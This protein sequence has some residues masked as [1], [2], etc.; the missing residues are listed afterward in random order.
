MTVVQTSEPRWTTPIPT[1]E[2]PLRRML[3][4]W[5]GLRMYSFWMRVTVPAMPTFSPQ[6]VGWKGRTSW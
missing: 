1:R 5:A 4:R 2:N 6:L 3:L